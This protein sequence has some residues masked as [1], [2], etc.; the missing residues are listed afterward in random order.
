M[1]LTDLQKTAGAISNDAIRPLTDSTDPRQHLLG[2]LLTLMKAAN[3]E[4]VLLE[5]LYERFVG[6]AE[7]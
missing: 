7:L 5:G 6:D 2:Q 3:L 1:N 4:G